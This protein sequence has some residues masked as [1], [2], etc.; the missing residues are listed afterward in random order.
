MA[1]KTINQR[2]ALQ[3]GEEIARQL[4]EL[5][6]AGEQAFARIR[7]SANDNRNIDL[8]LDRVRSQLDQVGRAG[9]QAFSRIRQTAAQAGQTVGQGNAP[10]NQQSG[11]FSTLAGRIT[12]VSGA[13]VGLA[14]GYFASARA[15]SQTIVD[16]G[17]QADAAKL[18]I[19]NFQNLRG[20]LQQLN[21]TEQEST[22]AT[23]KL[24]DALKV[25]FEEG[26]S[27]LEGFGVKFAPAQQNVRQFG[28]EIEI[29]GQRFISGRSAAHNLSEAIES[30]GRVTS[31]G[32]IQI[33]DAT[34]ALLAMRAVFDP[35][36]GKIREGAA[37]WLPFVEGVRLIKDEGKQAALVNK[38]FGDEI[39]RTLLP[40][41]RAG[42]DEFARAF[43]SIQRLNLG[44]TEA[45]RKVG[46]DFV[47]AWTRLGLA[48]KQARTEMG[49]AFAPLFTPGVNAFAD[50]LRSNQAS[51]ARFVEHLV[52][53][54]R[55]A[56]DAFFRSL[57]SFL[58][59]PA[60]FDRLR[61]A[62]VS[63]GNA[64]SSIFTSIILPAFRGLID[65]AGRVATA[66]NNA[67]GTSLSP[68]LIA[69]GAA[70]TAMIGPFNALLAAVLAVFGGQGPDFDAFREKLRSIGIDLDGLRSLAGEAIAAMVSEF[71]RLFDQLSGGE[72]VALFQDF[73]AAIVDFATSVPGIIL[74]VV[75]AVIILRR[76]FAGTATVINRLFGT[77]FTA[78]GL[79]AVAILGSISGAFT[80][81]AAILVGLGASLG[82]VLTT[83]KII[84]VVI[85]GVAAIFAI[86]VAAAT[87]LVAAIV[88]A[89]VAIVVF[90]DEIKAGAQ[91][92]WDFLKTQGEA[93]WNF[94][95][96]A[97]SAAV[98]SI[99]ALFGGLFSV[100]VAPFEA[101]A[102]VIIGIFDTI[103]ESIRRVI[104][105]AGQAQSAAST[106]GGGFAAG[107]YTGNRG[108]RQIA[109][110][111]H[112]QEYVQPAN[113]VR[114]PG[115]LG[116]LEV[117]RRTG[118][119]LQS[120]IVRFSRGYSLGGLV[121]NINDRISSI[122]IPGYASGGLVESLTG[123]PS[124][125][126]MLTLDMGGGRRAR[127][128]TDSESVA[129]LRR[130]AIR[131]QM[132][133]AGR[134]I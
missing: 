5:G 15:A 88:A 41:I 63:I 106:S 132:L 53:V 43:E 21:L 111:V 38:I 47:N 73:R 122:M 89:G 82:I 86:P 133:S 75:T 2:L 79:A 35:L 94:I 67:L 49:L 120:T 32:S 100:L 76:A 126:G 124:D 11:F 112:G 6:R 95:V 42:N 113:V 61:D 16:L 85:A 97:A 8:N 55:P 40:A 116:F 99:T 18:S 58:N 74:G 14:A 72:G 50:A 134:E 104:G 62:I 70:V 117:L 13:L 81:I 51:I 83:L 123:S 129:A 108:V 31:N 84:G 87:A 1:A 12:L 92:A 39:G 59:N 91:S 71:R 3:G 44:F 33:S 20:T 80:V 127:I 17:R 119:D 98:S 23:D 78:G 34:R 128:L 28:A 7:S 77:E 57:T 131:N 30:L 105:A 69:V 10:I 36:T 19:T 37:A 24:R 110:F 66:I 68:T 90:W 22:Q 118:G 48:T 26:K 4:S 96:Q 25:A 45:Q 65:I 56:V 52:N 64:V 115:V 107:G 130:V 102:N 125:F 46:Q 9:E 27:A 109:G 54:A 103:L 93:A 101:A 60:G 29:F 114:Q 121:D